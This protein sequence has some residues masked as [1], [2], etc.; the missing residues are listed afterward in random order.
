MEVIFFLTATGITLGFGFISSV[1]LLTTEWTLVADSLWL[2]SSP[3]SDLWLSSK[4][5]WLPILK[6]LSL[7]LG[8]E[9][10]VCSWLSWSKKSS[11]ASE[12][13]IFW[14]KLL[15]KFKENTQDDFLA[16][17]FRCRIELD[18]L[19]LGCTS[20]FGLSKWIHVRYWLLLMEYASCWRSY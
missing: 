2:G 15:I 7:A 11:A 14:A 6:V 18:V 20:R 13:I 8:C 9:G 3:W 10:W 12:L 4:A 5:L 19:R 16:I 1:L 17:I